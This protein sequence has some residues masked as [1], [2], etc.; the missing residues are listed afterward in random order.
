MIKEARAR[1]NHEYGP[2]DT[3][4]CGAPFLFV[5]IN[6]REDKKFYW[7]SRCDQTEQQKKA[8]R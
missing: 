4:H 7:C 8:R 6:Q 5:W 1:Q 2:G 3:C